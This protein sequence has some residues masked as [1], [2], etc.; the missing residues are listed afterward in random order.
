MKNSR[1]IVSTIREKH[2]QKNDEITGINRFENLTQDSNEKNVR[3][4]SERKTEAEIKR[5]E[6]HYKFLN[7]LFQTIPCAIVHF[8]YSKVPK[9]KYCNRSAV[10]FCGFED[11]DSYDQLLGVGFN[12]FIPTEWVPYV[13][14]LFLQAL[15]NPGPIEFEHQLCK[16][17]G[18]LAWIKGV[19]QHSL[20]QDGEPIIQS[21][22]MDITSQKIVQVEENDCM[23]QIQALIDNMPAGVAIYEVTDRIRGIYV[24]D[25]LC[26][27]AGYEIDEYKVL[28]EK[29][30]L[31]GVHPDDTDIIV[32]KLQRCMLEKKQF[33]VNFRLVQKSKGFR[34]VNLKVKIIEQS[35]EKVVCYAV[36]TDISSLKQS[37]QD[38]KIQ[39]KKFNIV[40]QNLDV[41]IWEYDI[42][43]SRY[44]QSKMTTDSFELPSMAENF[45]ECAIRAGLIFEDDVEAFRKLHEDINKGKTIVKGDFKIKNKKGQYLSYQVKYITIFDVEGN[46]IKAIGVAENKNTD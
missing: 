31:L 8:S 40:L 2:S 37:E 34:W 27:L 32:T 22:Y 9:M 33:D 5:S 41:F 44:F 36:Y 19:L 17:D 7:N 43:E 38:A 28:M 3:Y 18:S 11:S 12:R 45:P 16:V 25:G 46:A 13:N 20:S 15:E 4:D 26:K 23:S 30:A 6:L 21:V 14:D 42:K 24:N 29:D 1:S 35:N 39:N 10:S